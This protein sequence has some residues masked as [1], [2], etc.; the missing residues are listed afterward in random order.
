VSQQAFHS[1]GVECTDVDQVDQV[2]LVVS[3]P[4]WCLHQ[5]I[6]QGF[7]TTYKKPSSLK[8]KCLDV[9]WE[10]NY[11]RLEMVQTAASFWH[12]PTRCLPATDLEDDLR[13]SKTATCPLA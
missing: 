8:P 6:L 4:H 2:S 10:T 7:M 11:E 13:P 1:N 9:F 3:S 5:A 12:I